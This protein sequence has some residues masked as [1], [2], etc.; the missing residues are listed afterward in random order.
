MQNSGLA[1]SLATSQFAAMPLV[2]VPGALLWDIPS[3][4]F[5]K[6]LKT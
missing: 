2:A 4:L 5:Q 1:T 6:M 3:L